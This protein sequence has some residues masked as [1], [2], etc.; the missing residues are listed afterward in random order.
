MKVPTLGT[1]VFSPTTYTGDSSDP[2]TISAGFPPDLVINTSRTDANVYPA[3][4]FFDRLRGN[5][6]S[7]VATGTQAENGFFATTVLG[8]NSAQNSHTVGSTATNY[9][10]VNFVDYSFRRAPS[11]MD[12]VCYTGNSV[13]GRQVTHNLGVAPELFIVKNRTSA[14]ENWEVYASTIGNTRSLLL[15]TTAGSDTKDVWNNTSPTST[16]IVVGFTGQFGSV[17]GS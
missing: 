11:Y 9:S 15:N 2:R 1:T 8:F 3:K 6:N 10:G 5:N 4:A 17:N 7:L 12:V 14:G 16:Y 13:T